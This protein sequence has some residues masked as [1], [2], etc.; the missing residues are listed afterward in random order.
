MNE[1]ILI[2]SPFTTEIYKQFATI[3]NW[4]IE[5]TMDFI[6]WVY[7]WWKRNWI[8][9][10]NNTHKKVEKTHTHTHTKWWRRTS[11]RRR[12][13]SN[14][15]IMPTRKIIKIIW[16][17]I[18]EGKRSTLNVSEMKKKNER[19]KKNVKVQ[20]RNARMKRRKIKRETNIHCS[21]L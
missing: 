8:P 1:A 13:E 20:R 9:N 2:S 16:I 14:H 17:T 7:N 12:D 4:M 11:M 6:R 3:H 21:C 10:N 18:I 19:N 5:S 15:I